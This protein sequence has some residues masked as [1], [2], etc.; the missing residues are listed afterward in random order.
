MQTD[1]TKEN[2]LLSLFDWRVKKLLALQY[3]RVLYLF[4]LVL[5]TGSVGLYEFYIAKYFDTSAP[6]KLLLG[7]LTFIGGLV[8]ILITR[9]IYEFYFAFFYIEKHLR[10]INSKS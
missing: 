9:I 6:L 1:E 3:F 10:E 2:F 8:A 5:I 7:I 4:M